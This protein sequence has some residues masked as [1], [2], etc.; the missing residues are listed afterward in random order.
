[1]A[2]VLVVSCVPGS[3]WDSG[4]TVRVLFSSEHLSWLLYVFFAQFNHFLLIG[5]PLNAP[6]AELTV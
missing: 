4:V 1:L 2:I 5:M 6:N 3:L